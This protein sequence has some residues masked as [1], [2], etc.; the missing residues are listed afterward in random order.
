MVVA[1]IVALVIVIFAA[2]ELFVKEGFNAVEDE[3]AMQDTD[4]VAYILA[5]DMNM[6]HS[7]TM[8]WA[9]RDD[10]V[11]F[12]SGA[13]GD[14]PPFIDDAAFEQV[15]VSFIVLT[16]VEG[17]VIEGRSYDGEKGAGTPMGE[18]LEHHL[19]SIYA[20]PAMA[21]DDGRVLGVL[22]LSGT[23][24]MVS[25][26][27]VTAKDGTLLGTI[28]MGRVFDE[29]EIARLESLSLF[30]ITILTYE[31]LVAVV[32]P[33]LATGNV[34]QPFLNW[35]G[36]DLLGVNSP[37]VLT[38]PT[39]ERM[40]GYVFVNDLYG[41][42]AVILK[43][44]MPRDISLQGEKTTAYFM[45][46]I[47]LT[48]LV[49]GVI[50]L[51][52]LHIFVFSRLSTFSVR[53]EE[54]GDER[55]FSARV[56]EDGDDEITSLSRSC[57][58]MLR[59]LETSQNHLKGRLSETE[60]Q[61]QLIFN[62]TKDVM[63]VNRL[64]SEGDG[65]GN[66]NAFLGTFIDINDAAIS[67]L[68]YTREEFLTMRPSEIMV[69]TDIEVMRDR[70]AQLEATET[71]L[72]ETEL[73]AKDGA[74]TPYEISAHIYLKEGEPAVVSTARDI[75]ERRSIERLK[76]EAFAQIEQNM[77]QFAILNDHLRNPLQAIVGL[78][79]LNIEDQEVVDKILSQAD[80]I[81]SYVNQLDRG[82]I[83][84]EQIRDWLRKYYEFK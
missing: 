37:V 47:L 6:L 46:W 65:E 35:H 66:K 52:L 3:K 38:A 56:P 51:G 14:G 23:P 45:G 13:A 41:D 2:S 29:Q 18:A 28:S 40:E 80:L 15:G 58:V 32:S 30:P 49:F 78:A 84:S 67:S 60:K 50:L 61:Y 22:M 70:I 36:G 62:S 81:D 12:M 11:R 55:D 42:P 16:D 33:E 77:V 5:S 21:I 82:W 31:E 24:Y 72:Y 19:D 43:V 1:V 44:E 74:T 9:H 73:V 10:L 48:G 4:K 34:G 71:L 27:Q 76:G 26:Q 57:N 17:A 7:V 39:D 59:E 20:F 54:I 79:I 83:E 53:M 68:G 75:T 63:L 69:P 25:S 8:E 64:G